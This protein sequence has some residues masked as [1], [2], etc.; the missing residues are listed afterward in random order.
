MPSQQYG[1]GGPQPGG[2]VGGVPYASAQQPVSPG[3]TFKDTGPIR[4][5]RGLPPVVVVLLIIAVVGLG[6]FAI[7]Q[8]GWLEGPI[9]KVQE[10]ASGIDLPDWLPFG[11]KDTVPPS[12]LNASA[13]NIS[14]GSAVIVWETDEPSTSQVM[15]CESTGGCTYTELDEN[16]VTDHSVNITDLKPNTQYHFTATS[17]D[18]AS[19]QGIDE[20][21]FTTLGQ[22]TGPSLVI[23]E[24]TVSGVTEVAGTITWTTD[25][26]STSQV[27]YGATSTYGST[28]PLDQ[29]LTTSHTATLTGLT[30]ATAYHFKVMSR[31]GSG[32]EAVSPDQTFTTNS[33]VPVSTEVGAEIGMRAPDFTLPT[34]D[35]KQISLSDFR[36]KIV[37]I[38]FWQDVQQSRNE[39]SVIQDTYVS[40]PRD[41]VAVL[42]I[43]WKQTLAI[44]QSVATSKGLTMPVLLDDNGDVAA[45]YS[46]TNS[47]ITLF[48]D[49]QGIVRNRSTYPATFKTVSQIQSI[50]NSIQ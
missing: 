18:A 47:P 49:G 43:S 12:V 37:M 2:P 40:L 9:N 20:G 39:L 23:S 42:A 16:P 13:A 41:E 34:L 44:T 19:N 29:T 1:A 22:A 28:A 26:P 27:S 17:T 30:A 46:I 48:I 8:T 36:G 11:N 3:T 50:I 14:S 35:G 7:Y 25:K 21:D 10:L 38:N 24:I 45:K 6:G 4:V 33:A 15:I 31:D 5:R 32:N